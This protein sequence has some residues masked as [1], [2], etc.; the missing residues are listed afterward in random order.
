MCAFL[1][2]AVSPIMPISGFGIF[3]S[4]TIFANYVFCILNTPAV[5]YLAHTVFEKKE[6]ESGWEGGVES[7][8][9]I[10]AVVGAPV[11]LVSAAATNFN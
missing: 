1:A 6:D 7:I 8:E 4:I 10:V 9:S 2:T 5:M 3:A 11:E